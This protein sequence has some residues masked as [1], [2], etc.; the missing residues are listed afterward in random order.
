M[1]R[2]D[3][4]DV[5]WSLPDAETVGT[6]LPLSHHRTIDPVVSKGC[7]LLSTWPYHELS[8]CIG[9]PGRTPGIRPR[10]SEASSIPSPLSMYSLRMRH[11][12][13]DVHQSRPRQS[14]GGGGSTQLSWWA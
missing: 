9:S 5:Q 11:Q 6:R 12:V 1:A 13:V 3:T 7:T 14:V 8:T 10:V 4:E 2:V